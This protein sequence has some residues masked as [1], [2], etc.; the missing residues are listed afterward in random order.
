[1]AIGPVVTRGYGSFGTVNLVV[2]RGYTSTVAAV[3]GLPGI[4][5]AIGVGRL[6]YTT[7]GDPLHYTLPM[8]R[9]G[10]TMQKED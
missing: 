5:Y 4:E 10:F 1:M 9:I 6:H 3:P 2:T 7:S 8:S